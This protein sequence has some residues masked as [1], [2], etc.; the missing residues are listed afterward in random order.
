VRGMQSMLSGSMDYGM[1]LILS[2][3]KIILVHE[4][5]LM[6]RFKKAQF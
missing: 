6:L 1:E 5:I 2:V 3:E 4:F